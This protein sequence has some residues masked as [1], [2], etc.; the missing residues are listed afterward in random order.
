F[1]GVGIGQPPEFRGF[2]NPLAVDVPAAR[3]AGPPRTGGNSPPATW[4]ASAPCPCARLGARSPAHLGGLAR[5]ARGHAFAIP[6]RQE[7]SHEQ[8]SR[9]EIERARRR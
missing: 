4:R 9:V 3:V 8:S 2:A 1:F 6:R 5:S 7:R